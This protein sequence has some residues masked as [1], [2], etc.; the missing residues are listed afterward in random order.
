M[1]AMPVAVGVPRGLLR[2]DE[3][4]SETDG[5]V[6]RGTPFGRIVVLA[7][8]SPSLA[9]ALAEQTE[10]RVGLAVEELRVSAPG[11]E[12]ATRINDTLDPHVRPVAHAF[13]FEYPCTSSSAFS[14]RTELISSRSS[15]RS[16]FRS[17]VAEPCP[18]G[19]NRASSAAWW[20]RWW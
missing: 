3:A 17:A 6:L 11:A 7:W 4:I 20:R 19:S 12:D 5:S 15:A 9:P 13:P 18:V 2:R 14:S 16:C 10:A 8:L 1:A